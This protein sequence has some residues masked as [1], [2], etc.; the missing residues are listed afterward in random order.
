VAVA[1]N[2]FARLGKYNPVTNLPVES[3]GIIEEPDLIAV[4]TDNSLDAPSMLIEYGY[5][6][7]TQFVEPE[8][9]RLSLRELAFHTYLGLEDFFS[10]GKSRHIYDT[11]V[12]PYLWKE[13]LK[14]GVVSTDAFALQTA[15]IFDGVY[16]PAGEIM[17]DCPRTGKIGECTKA[18]LKQFQRK[19][20]LKETGLFDKETIEHLNR[21]YAG[22]YVRP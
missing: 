16:P 5:I 13:V 14:E 7:E 12:L 8:I 21:L 17:N 20:K 9:R 6:Y 19:Y 22:E 11:T 2:V 15:L 10:R 3:G 18:S 1:R 4:G